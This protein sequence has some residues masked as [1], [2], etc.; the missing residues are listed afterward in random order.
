M[1]SKE[2]IFNLALSALLLQR[3]ITN[4]DTDMSNEAKVLRSVWNPAFFS[5]LEDLDL[6]AT[7]EIIQLELIDENPNK[8]WKYVYK[9]PQNCALFRRIQSC[10]RKDNR[11]T[12]IPKKVGLYQGERAIFTNE[13]DAIGEYIPND[14]SVTLLSATAG[15]ALSLRL[16]LMSAPLATGKGATVLI[17]SLGDRYVAAKAEAQEQDKNE[18]FNFEDPAIESEF[19]AA[20]VSY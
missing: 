3:R 18:N 14:T 5:T 17:K 11:F 10:V 13:F 9:Y 19:V 12:Q 6:D 1:Y 4:A 16:A 2:D 20:R 15:I 8:L 7:S